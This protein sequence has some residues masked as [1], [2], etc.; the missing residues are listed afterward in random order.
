MKSLSN[1][2]VCKNFAGSQNS[3]INIDKDCKKTNGTRLCNIKSETL[4]K[5]VT[6]ESNLHI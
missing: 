3:K 5:I 1:C 6:I 4:S 2:G